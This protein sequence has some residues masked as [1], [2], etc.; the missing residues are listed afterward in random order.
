MENKIIEMH[1]SDDKKNAC[2]HYND[3][4]VIIINFETIKSQ[5]EAR[6]FAID[7]Q[8]WQAEQSLSYGEIWKWQQAFIKLAEKF[9]LMEEFKENGII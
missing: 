4:E 8:Q 1:I 3:G 6:N 7:W 9:D 2:L 5:E